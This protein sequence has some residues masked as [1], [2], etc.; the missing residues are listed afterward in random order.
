MTEISIIYNESLVKN[1]D[2]FLKTIDKLK[3]I[4]GESVNLEKNDTEKFQ[5]LFNKRIIYCSDDHFDSEP[6]VDDKLIKKIPEYIENAEKINKSKDIS[7]VDD[8]GIDDF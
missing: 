1:V 5:I 4:Y 3:S 8:I 6:Q 2:L 7:S